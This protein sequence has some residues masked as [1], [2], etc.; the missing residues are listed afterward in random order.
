MCSNGFLL[1]G[2]STHLHTQLSRACQI[3]FIGVG[4]WGKGIE[5]W[6]QHQPV[7][8]FSSFTGTMRSQGWLCFRLIYTYYQ[9]VWSLWLNHSLMSCLH[10]FSRV[11]GRKPKFYVRLRNEAP[12]MEG[13]RLGCADHNLLPHHVQ[14]L[15]MTLYCWEGYSI[16][17]PHWGLS[18]WPTG[19]NTDALLTFCS[20]G[21]WL[22]WQDFSSVDL[23]F[24]WP[25]C[26]KGREV[27]K[28]ALDL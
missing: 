19:D 4:G 27:A 1:P 9:M 28:T 11:M 21:P 13:Q 23:P 10:G 8:R 18:T 12:W 22:H 7:S 5:N 25:G 3:E 14:W 26:R 15:M 2:Q 24:G 17:C 20:S 16:T 6:I